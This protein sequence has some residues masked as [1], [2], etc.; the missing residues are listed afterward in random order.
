MKPPEVS[1]L[2]HIV[3]ITD[4]MPG[5]IE[6][7]GT[8]LGCPVERELKEFGLVQIRAGKALVDLQESKYAANGPGTD[9]RRNMEHFCLTLKVWDEDALIAHLRACNISCDAPARRYGA[10]GYGPSIYINDPDGNR[11]ELKGPAEEGAS[12]AG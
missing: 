4:N 7:Y 6:F 9:F 11:I 5:M 10:E 12:G 1:G 8:V 3:L 2:D